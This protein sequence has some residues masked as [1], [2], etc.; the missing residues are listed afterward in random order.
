M[1]QEALK[2]SPATKVSKVPIHRC[3]DVVTISIVAANLTVVTISR[4][5]AVL[6]TKALFISP[7]KVS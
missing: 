2:Q 6:S 1:H 5:V 7:R 3:G 4:L